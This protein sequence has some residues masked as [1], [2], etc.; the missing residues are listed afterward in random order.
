MFSST[1][2]SYQTTRQYTISPATIHI[3][4]CQH[5]KRI[6]THQLLSSMPCFNATISQLTKMISNH[7]A[8]NFISWAIMETIQNVC[9][10]LDDWKL[11]CHQIAWLLLQSWHTT[12][13]NNESQSFFYVNKV[14]HGKRMHS[15]YYTTS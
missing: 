9:Y 12:K 2:D 8:H 14:K 3:F 6:Q 1:R 4:P 15:I 10:E 11:K 5:K 13:K 7:Q